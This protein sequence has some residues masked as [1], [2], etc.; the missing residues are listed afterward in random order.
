MSRYKTGT[1]L[2]IKEDGDGYEP[3][4][5]EQY[6]Q[7]IAAGS[8]AQA[9]AVYFGEKKVKAR[10]ICEASPEEV[11]AQRLEKYRKLYQRQ[12]KARH[13]EMTATKELLCGYNLY[14]TNALAEKLKAE[15]VFLIYGLRWQIELLFKMWKSLLF[16]DKVGEMKIFSFECFFTGGCSLSCLAQN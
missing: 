10:L 5:I 2:Y 4:D 9:I 13:W 11:K 3:L 1:V 6:V 8:L 16:L 15:D 14:V 12:N 7:S